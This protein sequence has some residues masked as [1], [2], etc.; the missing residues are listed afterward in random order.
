MDQKFFV[1][2]WRA[3]PN[4]QGKV[5]P[6]LWVQTGQGHNLPQQNEKKFPFLHL[7]TFNDLFVVQNEPFL[8]QNL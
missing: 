2:Q 6:P 5:K 7:P 1:S 8:A 3:L 4:N